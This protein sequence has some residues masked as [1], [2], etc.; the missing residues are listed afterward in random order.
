[1]YR[2]LDASRI[3]DTTAVLRRRIKER[4][5]ESSL[6]A[7]CADLEEVAAAAEQRCRWIGEPKLWLRIAVGV[8]I[9]G[10]ALVSIT[11]TAALTHANRSLAFGE[12][13]Q[14]INATLNDLVLIGAAIAFLITVETRIKRAQAL[15]ALH[16]LRS[17][18]HVIDMHQL[19]KDPDRV[20][21]PGE[22][23]TSSPRRPLTPFQ[24][25]RY[26]DYCSEMLSITGKIAALYAQHL[27]DPVVLDAVTEIETLAA[28]LSQKIWQK[29]TIVQAAIAADRPAAAPEERRPRPRSAALDDDAR[30]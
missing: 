21:A 24:L 18:A 7:V 16:E 6:S 26:L 2:R 27:R 11:S 1:M 30:R 19:T 22:D 14:I 28:R 13:V 15:T 9:A 10:I 29:I 25:T 8:V 17:L 4:F 5:P 3:G 23:T 12:Y 20:L